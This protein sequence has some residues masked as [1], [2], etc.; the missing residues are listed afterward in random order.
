VLEWTDLTD[1]LTL[2]DSIESVVR[3]VGRGDFSKSVDLA[4]A[5]GAAAAIA[6]GVNGLVDVMGNFTSDFGATI[7]AMANGDFSRTI[8][9][10]YEGKFGDLKSDANKTVTK[11]ADIVSDI[12]QAAA[13]IDRS[14]SEISSGASQLSQRTESTAASL[15]ETSAS[16]IEV[17]TTV[18]ETADQAQKARELSQSTSSIAERGKSVAAESVDAI[19]SVEAASEKVGAI[20]G[21]IDEIAFQTN[22]LALN[23]SVEAARAGEAGKG[24]AVV[25][26]EV[27]TLAQRSSD[28]AANIRELIASS[29][30]QVKAG[31]TLAYKVGE[32]LDEIFTSINDVAS[33]VD[34]IS[35]AAGEQATGVSE[36]STAISHM[37]DITQSNASMA[38]DTRR[39]SER[40]VEMAQKLAA[41]AAF[42]EGGGHTNMPRADAA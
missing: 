10:D 22:L 2:Q 37:D 36:I 6:G 27:R 30:T 17:T 13:E 41:A 24:F 14:S 31:V 1:D 38:Q 12:R 26:S 18:K 21:V 32:T 15:E 40:L 25:A 9:V 23:A 20:V 5:D 16:T 29:Q 4:S 11:I 35:H 19:N 42:F 33:I 39:S 28:A 8:D 34:Q 3:A 7:N